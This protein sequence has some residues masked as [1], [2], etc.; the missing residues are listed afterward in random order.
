[1]GIDQL[2]FQSV[3]LGYLKILQM[4][5]VDPNNTKARKEYEVKPQPANQLAVNLN[6]ASIPAECINRGNH[7][8]V[9]IRPVS[10]HSSVFFRHNQSVRHHSDD[11]IVPFRHDTS[12][13]RS[14]RGSIS[15]KK[16]LTA[17]TKKT[18]RNT[19]PEAHTHRR[20]LYSTVV[21]THQLTVS[22]RFLSNVESGFLT[23]INWKSYS[24]RAQRHQYPSKQRR[25]STAIYRRRVRMNSNYRGFTGEND[26]EYQ[27]G[28]T[29]RF[30]VHSPSA[31]TQSPSLAQGELLATPQTSTQ[32]QLLVYNS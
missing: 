26:E 20:T 31:D 21:K 16:L 9:I 14:Q 2:G 8:S 13:C 18:A 11:I 28:Y 30:D 19:Y 1:M 17:R 32:T 29:R 5:N 10:H 27:E 7:R 22:S 12:V 4:D 15:A 23:G 25:K 6:R 24:R 3:Q